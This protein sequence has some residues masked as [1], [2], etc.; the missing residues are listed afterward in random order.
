MSNQTVLVT[1]ASSGIGRAIATRLAA[2]NYRVFGTSRN[3]AK[4]E[5]LEGIT[6]LSLDVTDDASAAAALRAVET[7]AG[8]LDILVNNAGIVVVGAVEE[9]TL[10]NAKRQ[11]ETNFF[12]VLRMTQAALP[13]MRRQRVGL[14]VN[15]GSIAGLVPIPFAGLYSASKLALQGLTEVLRHEVVAF[16]IRVVLVEPGFFK[17]DLVG[18][19]IPP[20]R[21]IDDYR[22]IKGR[23]LQRLG[24]SSGRRSR[25]RLSPSWCSPCSRPQARPASSDREGETVCLPQA[26]P[27]C[28]LVGAAGEEVL[29]GDRLSCRSVSLQRLVEPPHAHA[30]R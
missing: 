8:R 22:E 30:S 15:V 10:A 4:L 27:A 1:G 17:S 16:G 3:P 25:P 18:E 29:E 14:I 21:E 28:Q 20:G 19:A 12:G 23:V 26:V 9:V 6:F 5:P 7:Q 2:A 13:L 24:R 11:F